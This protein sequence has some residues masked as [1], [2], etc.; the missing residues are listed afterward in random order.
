MDDGAAR[1]HFPWTQ[2]P[3]LRTNGGWLR[4][5]GVRI[6]WV[7]AALLVAFQPAQAASCSLAPADAVPAGLR[8]DANGR[9][10]LDGGWT[11]YLD[12][13][14]L[15][16]TQRDED[17]TGGL[18]LTLAGRRAEEFPLP[19]DPILGALDARVLGER[20]DRAHQLHSLQ[21]GLLAF[22]PG[23]IDAQALLAGDR[24]YASLLYLASGRS[25]VS[26]FDGTVYHTSLTLG[27]LG[28]ALVPQVQDGIHGVLGVQRPQGW[29]H[30]IADGGEPTLRYAVTRQDRLA[31][32]A[33]GPRSRYEL[34]GAMAAS[35]G[36]LTEA[37]GA[38]SLRWG[39]I[40]TPWW[41]GPPDRV[42][43]IAEPAPATGG[44]MMRSDIRELYVWAGVK[45]HLRAYNAFLQGQFRS[46][47]LDYSPDQL[48]VLIGEAWVGVTVQMVG[49]VR[50]SWVLR[51][52]T[53]ELRV[54]PGDRSLL[55]GGLVLSHDL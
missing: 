5:L 8:T 10:P 11:L 6:L 12:N 47:D 32:A 31:A 51:Y 52:Q 54:E 3:R 50:L 41:S 26:D 36:Y 14:A 44:S 43:Y 13:D 37:S 2:R 42:E 33:T 29:D 15:T 4:R 34:K 18:A 9:E 30:Q 39:M 48:Q 55:W 35:L 23:D 16:P 53:S 40:N 21:F 27:V 24:P 25:Y 20:C 45:G 38:L 17:Y 46:S 22:T 19:L 1:L 49:E 7:C 28:T